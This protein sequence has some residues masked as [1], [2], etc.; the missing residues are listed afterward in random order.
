MQHPILSLPR[1]TVTIDA[2]GR[3]GPLELWRHAFSHG[4]INFH[5]LPE[6]VVEGMRLLHPR[7]VRI[8]VQEFFRVCPQ[9]GRYDWSRL[10]PYMEA[11][12]RTGAKVVAALTIKPK[13]LFPATDHSVWQPTDRAAWQG[14]LFEMARRYSRERG[15]VSHWEIGNETDIGESGGSPYL[16]PDPGDYFEF[17]RTAIEPIR[18][19]APG[20]EVGGPAACWIDNEPLP[21]FVARCKAS[22]TPLNF[23]SWHIY[24]DDA[25]RHA[26][27]VEKAKRLLA[28]Y[29][30]PR[31]EMMV[32]EWSKSF[33]PVSSEDLAY[34]PGRAAT[35]AASI[36]A[37][38]DAG[39][40]WSFYYHIWDQ[41][42]YREAFAPFFSEAGVQGM[43]T[44]WNE[45][46]HRFG[47]FGVDEEARPQYFV[48][49]M[50]SLMGPDR[51]ST[52]SDD[53]DLRLLASRAEGRT[54]LLIANWNP[55]QAEDKVVTLSFQNLSPG[56]K[57]LTV[58]RIDSACR[59]SPDSLEMIPLE[60]RP[61]DTLSDFRCQLLCPAESVSLAL[62]D[63]G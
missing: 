8:F 30:G 63:E 26:L 39:L 36:I 17:Y 49:R 58:Y 10:D 24:N 14:L 28:D 25:S 6:R 11:L 29:P 32:T 56:L 27:G 22:G 45:V 40:D 35:I 31:P 37:M 21:G 51:L 5:P 38:T 34:A 13:P 62:L 1:K 3:S 48:Y 16:I 23:V 59:W 41:V 61:V 33:D 47:L 9:A 46:P 42:C 53:P 2:G 55:E 4:G 18:R 52:G 43:L 7:L 54:A 44:H 50:L 15:I 57:R 20:A 12:A 60:E 19:A